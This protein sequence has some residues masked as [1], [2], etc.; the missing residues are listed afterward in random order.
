M[1]F[2]LLATACAALASL[3]LGDARAEEATT[4]TVATETVVVTGKRLGRVSKGATG[5]P[6]EIKET[7]QTISTVGQQEMLDYGLSGSNDALRL[8]TGINVEQYETNRAV[9]NARGFEV[10]LTQVDGLGMTN[11]WGTVVGQMDTFLFERIEL[12]RG[13]NGLLTGVGNASGTINYIRKR[14]TN[15]D[16]GQVQFS[17]GSWGLK[18]GA[19]DYNKV[20]TEDGSWAARL[21]VAHEDKDSYLRALHDRRS[22]VY[23][24]V[25]GQIGDDGVLTLGF[26]HQDARQRSPMWGS[27]TLNRVDGSRVDFD[28]SASTSQDWTYW[29]TRSQSAFVEYAHSLGTDWEAKLTYTHRRGEEDVRLLYAFAS[30]GGLNADNTGLAGWPYASFVTTRND[31]V[32]ANLSGEFKALGRSHHLITGISHSRQKTATDLF[33]YDTATYQFLPLPAFPYGGNVYP[34]PVWGARTPSTGGTQSLTRLYAAAQLGLTEEAK[35]IVGLNVVRL[36]REGSSLYGS[37]ATTNAYPTTSEVSPYLGLTYALTP[38]TLAYLSYSDIFQNQDHTDVNGAYLAPM[39][40]VNQEVG[41]KAQW[42]G[43]QL[44]TTFALFSAEQKG[45]ATYAGV[46]SGGTYYYEPKDVTSRGFEFEATGKL[47]QDTQLTLGLTRLRLT[48]PDG[49]PIYEWVPRTTAN[50]RIDTRVSGLPALR[51]GAAARWQSGTSK[52]GAI[53][54][55]SYLLLNAFAAYRLSDAATVRLNLNN[56]LNKKYVGGLVYGAIYGAPRSATVSLEYTL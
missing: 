9:F 56:V 54:Q 36:R 1:K 53:S 13:A 34:E 32:D 21:V 20:L 14:P 29:N 8:A 39:K 22:T 37:A 11:D 17:A 38:D 45:M 51:V 25:D 50:A 44:L 52:T 46:T 43:Q 10:Q 27:L 2:P 23:G 48:G 40:G 42:L 55:S 47:G 6:L 18:R 24:V 41:I 49:Q 33:P 7:P 3:T 4:E 35:A 30:A 5:L 28:T 26:T 19:L 31:I 12:I 15:V 16:G